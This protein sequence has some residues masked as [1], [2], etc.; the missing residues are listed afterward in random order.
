MHGRVDV[1]ARAERGDDDRR[2]P[3]DRQRHIL[4]EPR[5]GLMHDLVD[6]ER[7]G[8][9]F[10]MGAIM[11]GERLGDFVQPLVEL[12]NRPRVERGKGADDPRLALGDHQRRMRDDEQRRADN[13]QPELVFEN[14]RQRHRGSRQNGQSVASIKARPCAGRSRSF[15]CKPNAPTRARPCPRQAGIDFRSD[16]TDAQRAVLP[17]AH[18]S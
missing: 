4:L 16:V 6:R 1:L 5:V 9:A 18:Y 2:L 17:P 12:R 11:R 14:V 15:A 13:G 8:R 3:L 10:R 7:R